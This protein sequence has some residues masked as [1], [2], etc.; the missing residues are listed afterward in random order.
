M[1]FLGNKFDTITLAC[2]RKSNRTVEVLRFISVGTTVIV[3]HHRTAVRDSLCFILTLLKYNNMLYN[4]F[5]FRVA[6]VYILLLIAKVECSKCCV[7]LAFCLCIVFHIVAYTQPV[8]AL[9]E[10]KWFSKLNVKCIVRTKF[11]Y[12][13]NCLGSACSFFC[14]GF[15]Q[16]CNLADSFLRSLKVECNAL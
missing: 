1:P 5:A 3:E 13:S 10:C 9:Y 6:I 8:V 15:A 7:E 11:C 14:F 4:A 2:R 16:H 12:G